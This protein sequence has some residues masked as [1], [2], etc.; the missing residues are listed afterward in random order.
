MRRDLQSGCW[1]QPVRLVVSL[2]KHFIYSYRP[3]RRVILHNCRMGREFVG[4]SMLRQMRGRAGRQGKAP[5]GETYLCCRENDLEQ[6]VEL[7]NAE[8]PAVASCLNTENRRIQRCV[9]PIN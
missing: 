1:Y 7:M 2:V 3:A 6:V 8:L 9:C 4:P 5:I